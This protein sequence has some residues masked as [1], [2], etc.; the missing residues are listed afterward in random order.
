MNPSGQGCTQ[1]DIFFVFGKEGKDNSKCRP[2]EQDLLSLYWIKI[3]D[4]Y[5]S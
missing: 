5:L 2:E 3:L 1:L 4:K